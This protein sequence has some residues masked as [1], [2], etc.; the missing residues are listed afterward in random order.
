MNWKKLKSAL[1][2]MPKTGEAGFEGLV[3]TLLSKFLNENFV[4]A[5][6]GDQPS[7]DARSLRGRT[8]IQAKRYL[9]T[10]TLPVKGI[11]GDIREAIRSLPLL[12][13]YLLAITRT[14][15]SQ[16]RWDAIQRETG[17]DIIVLV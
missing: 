3:A 14:A 13:A 1:Q 15:Q 12:D 5:R 17:L 16:D 9:D 6:V 2:A 11:E 8:S 4:I 10:T 7:G